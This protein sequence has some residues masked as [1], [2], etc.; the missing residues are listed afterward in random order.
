MNTDELRKVLVIGLDCAPPELIFHR[1]RDDLPTI[2]HL[3][4]TGV[5]GPLN[6]TIPPITVPAW[7]SMMT[8]KDPGTLGF[9]GLRNRADYSYTRL[10]IANATL[11]N[12][13]TVW[14]ILS[15][16]G[17][18]V[19]LVGVPQTYPPRAVNGCLIASFLTPSNDSVYTYPQSLKAEIERVADGYVIDVRDFRTDDKARLL[20]DI[21]AMTEK[22]FR[23]TRHLVQTRD[24]DFCM[25]V[26]MGTDRIHHGFWRFLDPI[27]RKRE[28][29]SEFQ[30]AIRDYYRYLDREIASLIDLAGE[31]AAIFLVSDHGAK[32]IDGGICINEWLIREGY[33]VPKKY[34]QTPAA[35]EALEID[36][37]KTTAWGAGGYYARIFLNIAGREPTGIVPP[38]RCDALCDE[39]SEKIAAIPDDRGHPLP[40]RVFK[41][42][43]IYRAITNIPPDLIVYFGDL[44]WR[45]VGTVGHRAI[46]TFE[47]DTGPDD[48]NHSQ[49]GVFI[50]NDG[51]HTGER[52]H[53][54]IRDVAPTILGL[55][56]MPIPTD[57]QGQAIVS[58]SSTP[59]SAARPS[60]TGGEVYTADEQKAIEDRL[61][62]LGYL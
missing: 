61:R 4:Q 51:T 24:W 28:L 52:S 58:T 26:E 22:R 18:K 31:D 2:R 50:L 8:G 1:F 45:S 25:H 48:A 15:A 38:E 30:N 29:H 62:A 20:R 42:K 14:D 49:H 11:V 23:V 53:L 56:G 17:K 13:D 12:D 60:H 57:M 36:W 32:R 41:P 37:T 54:D 44:L 46:H 7:M 55:M 21:Y 47:N 9:Y 6:S 43:E 33:L 3:M 34:P 19:I 35:F 59:A 10:S 40:T 27:H 39:L 16:A 5:Y